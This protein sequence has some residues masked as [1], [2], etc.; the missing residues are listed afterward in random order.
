[1]GALLN[2]FQHDC[3]DFAAVKEASIRA[4]ETLVPNWLPNGKRVGN[5]WVALNPT[6]N[7]T[8]LGSFSVN[9][10]TGVFADFA[11]G[12]KGGDPIDLYV[13]L[14][15]VSLLDAATEIGNILGVQTKHTAKI[16]PLPRA[17]SVAR[18]PEVMTPDQSLRDPMSFPHRTAPDHQGKPR[19][20]EAG[21]GGPA[22]FSDEERRHFY[23]SG[24]TPIKIKV[25]R[26]NGDA[27]IWYRVAD[28][29]VIGWQLRKPVGFREAP[30]IGTLDPFDPDRINEPLYWPEGE[31]DTDSV[32]SKGGLAISFGGVGDGLPEGCEEYFRGRDVI[33]LAD[34]DATGQTHAERKAALI[35]P[36]ATSVR[37]VHFTEVPHK[38]DVSDYFQLGG[39][40]EALQQIVASTMPYVPRTEGAAAALPP[41]PTAIKA[42]PY[43]W[44]DPATIPRRDFVYGRHLIRKFVSATVAPGGVGKSSL[45][46]TE[47]LAMVSGR[48]LLGIHPPSR[49][50]VWLWNLEDP[51]EETARH[52][53]ATA[54]HYRLKAQDIEGYLFTDSGR[55]QRLV[56]ATTDRNGTVIVQPVVDNIVSEIVDREIDVLIIDPFVSSHEAPENDNGAMDRIVKEWGRVAQRGNCAVELIHHSRKSSA[57]EMEITVESSRG[58]KALTD[59]CRSVRVLNRMS[60]EEGENAGVENPRLHFRTYIDKS[61]LAPPA[62]TSTWFKLES[63]DLG[64]GN[65]GFGDSVGVVVPWQWPDLMADVSVS[66]LRM[67]QAIVSKG[68]YRASPQAEDWVGKA[69][70]EALRLDLSRAHDKRKAATFLKIW[71]ASGALKKVDEKDDKGMSRPFIVVGEWA[72]D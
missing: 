45:I 47:T 72:N 51:A 3:V 56:I 62:E 60:K 1:M 59:G 39:T 8:K 2:S 4:I 42:T 34:N 11:T 41:A 22:P 15:R 71:L 26:N 49:S 44:I 9:L 32:T 21:D 46:V 35:F 52:I 13:Y 23:K 55:D 65:A 43:I 7:D 20:V 53:Q 12:D 67:V 19:F 37:V 31:K 16:H 28:G 63:V 5:E 50:R 14:N 27:Q 40:W 38:G 54:S 68:R 57:G 30:F 24:S 66:D 58:G 64:N 10:R 18:A 70:A 61:N 33:V 48:D 29:D 6:R 25:M 17:I 36:I 69:I